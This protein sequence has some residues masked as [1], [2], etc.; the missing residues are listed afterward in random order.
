[1]AFL[2]FAKAKVVAPPILSRKFPTHNVQIIHE[3]TE[4]VLK[5][6]KKEENPYK[7]KKPPPS[8]RGLI[9]LII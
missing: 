1:M 6:E 8:G 4:N 5:N 9:K 3:G 2:T 7:I